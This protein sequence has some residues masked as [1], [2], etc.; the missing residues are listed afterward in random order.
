[1]ARLLEIHSDGNRVFRVHSQRSQGVA[2]VYIFN[3]DVALHFMI[4]LSFEVY[5]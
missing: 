2:S 4:L 3:P 1:M 5:C